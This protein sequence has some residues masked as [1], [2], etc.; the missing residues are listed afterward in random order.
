MPPLLHL[1]HGRRYCLGYRSDMST[2]VA[3]DIAHASLYSRMTATLT[4]VQ[5][6][7]NAGGRALLWL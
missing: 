4:Q 1:R 6:H 7:K 5:I 3:G 2:E